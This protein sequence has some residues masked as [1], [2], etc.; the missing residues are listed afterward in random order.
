MCLLHR[1]KQDCKLETTATNL[2]KDALEIASCQC[3][4]YQATVFAG[5]YLSKASTNKNTRDLITRAPLSAG[6][7]A[8]RHTE[9]SAMGALGC[10]AGEKPPPSSCRVHGADVGMWAGVSPPLAALSACP[11]AFHPSRSSRS[12]HLHS[13]SSTGI[14]LPCLLSS[15]G[16]TLQSQPISS[17]GQL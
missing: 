5:N 13:P 1:H 11:C 14:I 3:F 6:R 9:A 15:H 10:S 4:A 17:S 16:R 2:A 7:L 12:S 8:Q